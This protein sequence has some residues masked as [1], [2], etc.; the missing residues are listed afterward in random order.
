MHYPTF[1]V[2]FAYTISLQMREKVEATGAMRHVPP[3]FCT[4]EILPLL[5]SLTLTFFPYLKLRAISFL[6]MHS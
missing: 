2:C 1:W 4:H 6:Q 5:L 3:F